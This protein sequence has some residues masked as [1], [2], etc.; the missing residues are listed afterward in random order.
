MILLPLFPQELA[1]VKLAMRALR[2][3]GNRRDIRMNI[4]IAIKRCHVYDD[5]PDT[6]RL[7]EHAC[8]HDED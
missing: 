2:V 8:F 3:F 7:I 1:F 5:S 6:V 4:E